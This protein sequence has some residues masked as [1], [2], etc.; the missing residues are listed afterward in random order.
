MNGFNK[1]TDWMGWTSHGVDEANE[2]AQKLL[3]QALASYQAEAKAAQDQ[4]KQDAEAAQALLKDT[5]D[6]YNEG[7]SVAGTA[8]RNKSGEAMARAKAAAAMN[9]ASKMQAILSG[10][11]AANEAVTTGYDEAMRSAA[12]QAQQNAATKAGN[13]QNTAANIMN[14]ALSTSQAQLNTAQQ[15][16]QAKIDAANTKADRQ[17]ARRNAM[18][19]AAIQGGLGLA[20]NIISRRKDS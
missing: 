7:N 3:A 11:Q 8:A 9:G 18:T 6:Y 13:A 12:S 2:E 10:A 19:S 15:Q 17:A 16:A 5:Q 20:G 4:Y 1:F 14:A